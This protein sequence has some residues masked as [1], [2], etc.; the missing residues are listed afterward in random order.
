MTKK[1]AAY[2]DGAKAVVTE[3]VIKCPHCGG[4]LTIECATVHVIGV[5][6]PNQMDQPPRLNCGTCGGYAV[7]QFRGKRVEE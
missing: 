2:G 6:G 7:A 3:Y 1:W 5:N 4:N